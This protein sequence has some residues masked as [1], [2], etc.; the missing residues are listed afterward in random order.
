MTGYTGTLPADAQPAAGA[1][2]LR[3]PYQPD[4]LRLRVAELIDEAALQ[5]SKR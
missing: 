2:L 1:P 5:G 4:A 3:K